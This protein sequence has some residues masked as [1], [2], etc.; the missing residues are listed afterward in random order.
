MGTLFLIFGE[1]G[2]HLKKVRIRDIIGTSIER[3]YLEQAS[4]LS[5]IFVRTVAIENKKIDFLLRRIGRAETGLNESARTL[6]RRFVQEERSCVKIRLVDRKGTVIFSTD[7]RDTVGTVLKDGL[8][9]DLFQK[10][11]SGDISPAVDTFEK[12][13]IFYRLL[14]KTSENMLLF[15]YTDALLDTVFKEADGIEFQEFSIPEA[16]VIV[17][18]FP[19]VDVSEQQNLRNL[20]D[21]FLKEKSG[22]LRVQMK[23]YDKTV[24]FVHAPEPLSKWVVAYAV[25]T[26]KMGISSIGTLVLVVQAVVILA[27]VIFIL[28]AV[29]TRRFAFDKGA[30]R[31]EI[32]A[33]AVREARGAGEEPEKE[34]AEAAQTP[35]PRGEELEAEE[36]LELETGVIPLAG[37]EEV[38]ELEEVGEAEIAQELEEV[39]EELGEGAEYMKESGAGSFEAGA[40]RAEETAGAAA[41]APGSVREEGIEEAEPVEERTPS[42]E[43]HPEGPASAERPEHIDSFEKSGPVKGHKAVEEKE[44]KEEIGH[45]DAVHEQ[46]EKN[47]SDAIDASTEIEETVADDLPS[48]MSPDDTSALPDLDTLVGKEYTAL[49][50]KMLDEDEEGILDERG[51]ISEEVPPIIP[52]EAYEGQIGVSRDDELAELIQTIEQGEPSGVEKRIDKSISIF[53]EFLSVFD[54]TRGALLIADRHNNYRPIFMRGFNEK[55]GKKLVFRSGEKII[56]DILRK[57]RI[58]FVREDACMSRF[59]RTKFDLFDSST[60]KRLFLVPVMRSGDASEKGEKP[61]AA[62]MLVCLTTE[63]E[64]VSNNILKAL[65]KI[66]IK[67]SHIV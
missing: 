55:T 42:D 63:D 57:N 52:D 29:R 7:T 47:E 61:P 25:D 48:G 51:G 46:G 4:V 9:D 14:S 18:N 3:E 41:E 50:E 15:Y 2:T 39:T 8:Y 60:I 30:G 34:P 36:V 59:F 35:E 17:V 43:K 38:V 53:G 28:T 58:L 5:N 13:F 22:A 49:K 62:V 33:M 11:S 66:K 67:L 10:S 1:N 27:I 23:G 21:M 54:L 64:K 6:I 32:Q 26:E 45:N 44:S 20:A 31:D 24:Y 56:S 12:N 16:G 40:G 37:V 19:P 65:K